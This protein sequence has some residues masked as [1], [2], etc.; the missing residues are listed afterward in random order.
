[1]APQRPRTSTQVILVVSFVLGISG[2][3]APP[4]PQPPTQPALP[5]TPTQYQVDLDA[6]QPGVQ[7]VISANPAIEVQPNH[8]TKVGAGDRIDL[9]KDGHGML[10]IPGILNIEL[11]KNAQVRLVQAEQGPDGTASFNLN[12]IQ[13]H[14]RVDLNDTA[15]AR[16]TLGTDYAT[17]VTRKPGTQ[18]I[19]CQAP[20]VITCVIVLK[21][22][23]DVSAQ[24][25]KEMLRAGEATYIL[26][27]Q[28]PPAAICAPAGIFL[29]WEVAFVSSSQTPDAGA[30]VGQLP[31]EPCQIKIGAGNYDIGSTQPDTNHNALRSITLEHDFWIDTYEVT[32]FLYKQ[33]LAQTGG[34]PPK[35]GLGEDDHPVEGVTWDQ[36]ASYCTWAN[37][38]L[39]TEQEWEV[40]GRWGGPSA[41]LYPWGNDPQEG[42]GL[43]SDNTY[44]VGSYAQNKSAFGVHD[45]VGSVWEW[46][47]TPYDTLPDGFKVL[48]GGR[49][50]YFTDLAFRQ[51]AKADDPSFV[52]YAG[53][54]CASDQPE[55]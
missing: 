35:G 1:M 4:T 55:E 23:A 21:G 12:Q 27:G 13:G 3:V 29:K 44:S 53:F 43:P 8:T 40:A 33:Y 11:F 10:R 45:M 22:A 42:W 24:G 17:I 50:G 41:R 25:K 38:R 15:P 14:I 9:D 48:R 34:Q 47:G 46:V 2:C 5:A 20:G 32:N 28:A 19:V 6:I 7:A 37:K 36:A 39:P 52:P 49:Y 51:P 30:M 54:R 16:L 31:K 26:K 18:F